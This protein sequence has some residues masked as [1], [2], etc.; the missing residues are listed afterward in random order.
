MSFVIEMNLFWEAMQ[1][2][3]ALLTDQSC[4]PWAVFLFSYNLDVL[5]FS[6]SC[7]GFVREHFF[8]ADCSKSNLL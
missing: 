5:L 7:K 3:N 1:I 2:K 4:Y 8:K 6:A